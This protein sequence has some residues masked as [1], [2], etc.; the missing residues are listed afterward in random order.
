M[1]FLAAA[2][3]A[4]ALGCVG[5]DSSGKP[6]G[7]LGGPCFANNTCNTGLACVLN[8]G[9]GVCEQPDATTT[10][11]PADSPADAVTDAGTEAE[12]EA[13]CQQ[14]VTPREPCSSSCDGGVCCPTV[15]TCA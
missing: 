14:T 7:S 15:G 13:S 9:S 6:P 2:S 10:D 11:A 3:C 8:N 12:A 1:R 5:G 4:L